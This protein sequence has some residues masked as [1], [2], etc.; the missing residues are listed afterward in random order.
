M[1]S[2]FAI[3]ALF[4]TCLTERT[5]IALAQQKAGCQRETISMSVSPDNA[6][7]A[8]VQEDICS[9]GAFVTTITNTILLV[10]HDSIENIPLA[11]HA[12]TP[13]HPNDIFTMDKPGPENRP[14]I[15][16]LSAAKLQVTVPNKSLIGLKKDHYDTI[17][18]VIKYEPDDPAERE[19]WRKSLG[20]S[21]E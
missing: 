15:R 19:R 17:E 18:I 2:I 12:E 7:I 5:E 11:A 9:D 20:L 10:R 6:W 3:A 1:R 14:T 4:V 8:L 16:W 21:A 13:A